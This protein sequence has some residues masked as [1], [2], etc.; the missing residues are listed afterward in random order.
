MQY[1]LIHPL[2]MTRAILVAVLLPW[3]MVWATEALSSHRSAHAVPLTC[4]TIP[5]LPFSSSATMHIC[6][7]MR[8]LLQLLP[9]RLDVQ[10]QH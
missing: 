7:G 2:P 8:S 4:V 9:L 3:T 1:Q 10:Q 6:S 5:P